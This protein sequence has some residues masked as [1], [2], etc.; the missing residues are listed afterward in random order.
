MK[1]WIIIAALLVIGLGFLGT[2]EKPNLPQ[3]T[4]PSVQ[5]I[6]QE[7]PKTV[8]VKQ[9]KNESQPEPL[10]SKE[11]NSQ[12]ANSLGITTKYNDLVLVTRVI[13]GDTI[14]VEGLGK[15]RLIGVDTPETVDPRKPVQCF[16]KEAAQKT[17]QMLLGKK[18]HLES[19]PTQGERD[20]YNRALRYVFLEDGTNFNQW[21]IENGYAHE[22]TY[23]LP[24][25]Y[26]LEFKNAEKSARENNRGLWSPTACSQQTTTQSNGQCL[27]KGNINSS[28]EKIYHV[29][30]GKYYDKTVIDE[31]KG[32][33]W[34]CSEAEAQSAGWRKSKK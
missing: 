3:A 32:E 21:L 23:N 14:E 31:S 4:K 26:Q 15:V 9:A 22:Y 2:R 5:S 17:T 34:F 28:G 20:K 29:P 10:S 25:K 11:T 6:S 8:K 18:V 24:Y 7:K 27:I 12:K 33:R 13:D 16:G 1:K 19:D 30:G